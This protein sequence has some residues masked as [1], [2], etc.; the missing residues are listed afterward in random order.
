LQLSTG[1]A[2]VLVAL[3][4]WVGVAVADAV[5]DADPDAEADA[6]PDSVV[7]DAC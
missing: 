2:G 7:F 5:A 6:D 3:G 4:G 1:E